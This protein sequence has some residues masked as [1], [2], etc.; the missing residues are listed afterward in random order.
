MVCV[1]HCTEICVFV[2]SKKDLGNINAEK[3]PELA[4]GMSDML[5]NELEELE[6]ALLLADAVGEDG[7]SATLAI[8]PAPTVLLDWLLL[9]DA[10]ASVAA[11]LTVEEDES[12]DVWDERDSVEEDK[13]VGVCKEESDEGDGIAAMEAIPGS[14]IV[15]QLVA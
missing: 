13:S 12:V 3:I 9:P 11:E 6:P 1:K 7:I 10:T 8:P 15:E 2:D 4:I 5:D 14:V